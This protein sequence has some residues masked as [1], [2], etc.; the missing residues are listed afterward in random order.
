MTIMMWRSALPSNPTDRDTLLARI[1]EGGLRRRARRRRALL[2]GGVAAGVLIVVPVLVLTG[3]DDRQPVVTADSSESTTTSTSTTEST[4]TTVTEE[5]STEASTTEPSTTATTLVCRNSDNPACG[6]F[7]WDPPINNQPITGAL[8][9]A[10]STPQAGQPVTLSVSAS[11][12]DSNP[13]LCFDDQET[14]D[15]LAFD[16]P[17]HCVYPACAI[18]YSGYGPHDPPAPQGGGDATQT[19]TLTFSQPGSYTVTAHLGSRSGTCGSLYDS[20]I[21]LQIS[22]TVT[23]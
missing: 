6:D 2:A 18:G 21:E 23:A 1:R 22:V 10:E 8:S 13:Q 19:V 5:P 14:V 12:P 16:L 11:D 3:S 7:Y 17:T 20:S 4:S 9:L 15:Q